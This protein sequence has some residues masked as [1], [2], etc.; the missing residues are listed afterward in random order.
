MSQTV[1]YWVDNNEVRRVLPDPLDVVVGD[2]RWGDHCE[3]FTPA[4]WVSQVWMHGLDSQTHS[5]YKAQG[6]LAEELVFCMLGGFGITAELAGAAFEACRNAKL[7]STKDTSN[8]AWT[9]VLKQPISVNSKTVH[10]RYPNQKA[11]YLAEAMQWLRDESADMRSGRALRDSLLQVRG[12][13]PKTAGWVS[14]NF[15]DSDDVAI[16]DIHI[17]R[18]GLL[19]GLFKPK[20]RLERDYFEMEA[21]Y[22]DFCHAVDVRPAVLDCLIWDQMRT[23]GQLA[24]EA[25][26]YKTGKT[27][28]PVR[29]PIQQRQLELVLKH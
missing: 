18:A 16:L 14:R 15:M 19:C 25:V 9:E 13:G 10:Y 17:V 4:F 1:S 5:P 8:Q 21:N 22:I 28:R 23:M 24:I 20:Q 6:S 12:V 27:V 2:I 7:I 26:L 3:L 29:R 11:I